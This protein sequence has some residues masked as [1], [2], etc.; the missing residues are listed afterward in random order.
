MDYEVTFQGAHK[1]STIVEGYLVSK[2]Y[3]FCSKREAKQLFLDEFNLDKD[4]EPKP[5]TQP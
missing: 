2:A 3:F 4:G 1:F 5:K